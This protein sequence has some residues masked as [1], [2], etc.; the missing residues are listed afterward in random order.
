MPEFRKSCDIGQTFN[1]TSQERNPVGVITRLTVG[2]T[3]LVADISVTDP[4]QAGALA[5]RG[6]PAGGPAIPIV[7]ALGDVSW[8]L[9]A[10]QPVAFSGV[11]SV[12]N[13]QLVSSYLAARSG[14]LKVS[15][16]WTVFD[17]DELEGSYYVCFSTAAFATATSGIPAKLRT[18]NP[19]GVRLAVDG[20]PITDIT[21]PELYP[22]TL[23]VGPAT[24][25]TLYLATSVIDK[26]AKS[27]G[28]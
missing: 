26:V 16:G 15:I 8:G 20:T 1:P 13:R 23:E 28:A 9:G 4:V 14:D 12:R 7:A 6:D 21:S 22:F 17:F 27:W 19:A 2:T 10:L 24:R 3:A 11:L 18:V 25:G 5:G